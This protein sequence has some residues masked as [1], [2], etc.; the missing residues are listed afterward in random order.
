MKVE[1]STLADPRDPAFG[2]AEWR[3]SQPA[4][5]QYSSEFTQREW[6]NRRESYPL[7]PPHG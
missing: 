2:F 3:R 5:A 4:L 7:V 6:I 1:P